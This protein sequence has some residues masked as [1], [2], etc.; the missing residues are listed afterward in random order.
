MPGYDLD[1]AIS[2]ARDKLDRE[3]IMLEKAR[4][5]VSQVSNLNAKADAQ[6][7]VRDAEQRVS[8]LE[9]EFRRLTQKR[10]DRNSIKS[11]SVHDGR[12]SPSTLASERSSTVRPHSTSF[13]KLDLRKA[14]SNLSGQKISLKVHE[15]AY[16]LEVERKIRDKASRIRTLYSNAQQ[17]GSKSKSSLIMD[18]DRIL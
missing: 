18:S 17:H 7:M 14:S 10:D 6:N 9:A 16:K 13:S 8:F 5:I 3:R 15:I 4:Q 2:K 11:G 1:S 12:S